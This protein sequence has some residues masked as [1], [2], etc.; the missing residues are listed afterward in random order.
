MNRVKIALSI[1]RFRSLDNQ[2]DPPPFFLLLQHLK[3]T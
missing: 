2:L 3:Q 1:A